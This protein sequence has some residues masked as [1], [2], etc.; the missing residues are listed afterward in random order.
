[1]RFLVAARRYEATKEIRRILRYHFEDAF[2]SPEQV[3]EAA[4]HL[5]EV[6]KQINATAQLLLAT[7]STTSHQPSAASPNVTR[8]KASTT[9]PKA[10]DHRWRLDSDEN[11][12]EVVN[13]SS[14]ASV[15]LHLMV[16]KAFCVLYHPLFK[17][18]TMSSSVAIRTK[19]SLL[20]V[21]T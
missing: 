18:T 3:H 5:G 12:L 2:Q 9:E 4:K 13:F 20:L 17:D 11:D 8:A 16:H 1:V 10:F 21:L 19:F 15:L 14:W 6:A 7:D